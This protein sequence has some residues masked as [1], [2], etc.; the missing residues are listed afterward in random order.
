MPKDHHIDLLLTT[1]D[2]KVK[3]NP[4]MKVYLKWTCPGCG[5]RVTATEPNTY[6]T[7]GYVHESCGATYRGKMFGTLVEVSR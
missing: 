1:L 7:E 2:E 6:Y 4:N 3:A 5:E